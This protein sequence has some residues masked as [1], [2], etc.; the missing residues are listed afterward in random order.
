MSWA[1]MSGAPGGCSAVRS[2]RCCTRPG[3]IPSPTRCCWPPVTTGGAYAGK[4]ARVLERL[5]DGGHLRWI[6]FSFADQHLAAILREVP[7][8]SGTR[9][10]PGAAPAN[11][12]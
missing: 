10:E 3:C 11:V 6:G 1:W 9:H 12:A 8:L 2:C 4:L 5:A 7:L